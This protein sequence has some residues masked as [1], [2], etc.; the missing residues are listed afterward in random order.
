MSIPD[1]PPPPT[2]EQPSSAPPKKSKRGL[3]FAFVALAIVAAVVIGFVIFKLV[4]KDDK[5]DAAPA[6]LE[7]YYTQTVDWGPCKG[8]EAGGSRI[9]FG[10][11]CARIDVPVD[12]DNPDGD[13]AKIAISRTR[14]TGKKIGSVLI[15]PGGPGASGLRLAGL[16]IGTEIGE[17]FDVIGFDPRGIGA[18]TPTIK[19]LDDKEKDADRQDLDI[20][21]SP[22][23]IK[24]QED[25]TKRD[26][27][28]CVERTGKDFLAHVGTREVAHDMDVIRGALGDEKLTYIGISYGTHIGSVYAETFPDKVRAMVLDG[29]VNPAEDVRE[30]R[31]KQWT[32]FQKAFDK[33]AAKCAE[34]PDCPLGTD[35]AQAVAAYRALVNPLIEKPATTQDPRGLGYNDAITGTIQALYSPELWDKLTTGLTELKANPQKGDA[36]LALSDDYLDRRED[37]TYA[38]QDDAHTAVLCVDKPAE[39]DRA[40]LGELDTEI[41][42]VAPFTDDGHGTGAAPLG[43]CALWP[44]PPTS[45]P[46]EITVKGLPDIV[47]VSTTGD[48]AT[49]YQAGVDLAKQLGGSLITVEGTQHGGT[50]SEIACVDDAVLAYI[51][52]LTK[53]AEGLTCKADDK[54]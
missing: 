6:G 16:G 4:T 28:K 15:N 31:I 7:K 53:P 17:R 8:Y 24:E 37:G 25:E 18:S 40:E 12:Y 46:H 23:G 47:V 44:V 30:S 29:A 22:A 2:P 51:N 48:P 13:Q 39:T 33:F 14:A 26:V 50:F 32:G 45:Q 1:Q 3:L 27:E 21:N 38:N 5:S 41:R 10:L 52:D 35:P 19:C 9:S 34:K 11:Q 36:L 43:S 54:K 42:K 49:P 20:D